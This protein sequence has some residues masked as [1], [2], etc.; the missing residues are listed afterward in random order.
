MTVSPPRSEARP[1]TTWRRSWTM[2]QLTSG[3]CS[4][5]TIRAPLLTPRGRRGHAARSRRSAGQPDPPAGRRRLRP[6]GTGTIRAYPRAHPG[7]GWPRRAARLLSAYGYITSDPSFRPLVLIIRMAVL[8]E[9]VADLRQSQQ[10]AAQAAG[11]LR[12]AQQFRAARGIYAAPGS[13]AS[14]PRSRQPRWRVPDSRRLPPRTRPRRHRRGQGRQRH[15]DPGS[16]HDASEQR[17][18]RSKR[19]T[20]LMST[21]TCSVMR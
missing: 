18:R 6:R 14:A 7:R 4:P 12:A 5:E 19:W 16:S 8:A 20:P 9:A 21:P 2:P 11:A 17:S 15:L 10:H 3:A 13:A 1:G